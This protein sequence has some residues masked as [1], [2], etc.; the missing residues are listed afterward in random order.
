MIVVSDT[1]GLKIIVSDTLGLKSNPRCLD[2]GDRHLTQAGSFDKHGLK[3]IFFS[4]QDDEPE[5]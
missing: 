1:L 2:T 4:L 5:S 3:V